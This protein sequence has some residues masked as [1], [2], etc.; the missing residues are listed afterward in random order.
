VVVVDKACR[1]GSNSRI[2][3]FGF[4]KGDNAAMALA[5][6]TDRPAEAQA[7]EAGE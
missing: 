1:N 2:P 3:K 7:V 4:R 5:E 6:L